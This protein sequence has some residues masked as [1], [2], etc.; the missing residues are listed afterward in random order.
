MPSVSVSAFAG[1]GE[2]RVRGK[3]MQN[4][5]YL[6]R[7]NQV[8]ACESD[9]ALTIYQPPRR[10]GNCSRDLEQDDESLPAKP[11]SCHCTKRHYS[12]KQWLNNGPNMA[13]HPV[14]VVVVSTPKIAL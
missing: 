4:V 10:G 6:L 7:H 1:K 9:A 3:G 14:D 13:A 11:Q 2:A 5:H 12:L 8:K